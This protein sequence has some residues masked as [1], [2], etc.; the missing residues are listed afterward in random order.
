MNDTTASKHNKLFALPDHTALF[1]IDII[2][3][4]A[5]LSF[6]TIFA[7]IPLFLIAMSI[8][9]MV[10]GFEE[11]YLKIK[12]LFF[13]VII[14]THQEHIAKYLDEF[15]QNAPKIGIIGLVTII[16]VLMMFFESYDYAVNRIFR[17]KPRR[18]MDALPIYWTFTTLGPLALALCMYL[19]GMAKY[20][21]QSMSLG[22]LEGVFNVMPY[23]WTWMCLFAVYLLSPNAKVR[24]FPALI[25]SF[26]VSVVWCLSK[27]IFA[28]YVI[29][30]KV[31]L[32]LYGSFSAIIFFL[33]W[34]Y[35]SWT[36]FLI[37][38]KG[39]YLLSQQAEG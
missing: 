36:V 16:F 27:M 22:W 9:P 18:F 20:A 6:Y 14:P 39:C 8:F 38:V 37:G 4:A 31:Y 25:A 12:E 7:I 10:P 5:S 2:F 23:F 29:Y 1:E 21:V 11:Y 28:F 35:L 30:N 3:F 32:S 19:L 34:I 33:L 24:C 15:L 17:S 13:S 26:V